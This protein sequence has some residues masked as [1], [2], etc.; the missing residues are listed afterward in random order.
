MNKEADL[1][2]RAACSSSVRLGHVERADVRSSCLRG[3]AAAREHA[4]RVLL[5]GVAWWDAPCARD[6]E[7]ALV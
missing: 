5:A 3:A 7:P 4:P 6:R 2:E 1:L